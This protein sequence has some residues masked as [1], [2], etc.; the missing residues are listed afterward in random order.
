MNSGPWRGRPTKTPWWPT[1]GPAQE[2]VVRD[3]CEYRYP[4]G[5]RC[6]YVGET[7]DGMCGAHRVIVSLKEEKK[8]AD[9]VRREQANE[10]RRTRRREAINERAKKLPPAPPKP[11]P[12]GDPSAPYCTCLNRTAD[13]NPCESC[14]KPH[15]VDW[16]ELRGE[17]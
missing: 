4:D 1:V 14:D 6:V 11:G 12:P 16:A 7:K 13:P 9:A 8:K 3:H 2:K 10:R 5:A 17:G 15:F